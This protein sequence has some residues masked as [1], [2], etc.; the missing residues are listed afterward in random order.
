M[1]VIKEWAV[2]VCAVAIGSSFCVFL[3]PDGKMKK[4][5]ESGVILIILLLICAPLRSNILPDF[6]QAFAAEEVYESDDS[7]VIVLYGRLAEDIISAEIVKIL[8]SV[9]EKS[10]EYEIILESTSENEIILQNII[11]YIDSND[12]FHRDEIESRVGNLTGIVPEV[13]VND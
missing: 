13:T 4:M 3:I 5:A 6:E 7:D 1:D 11:I 9:C 2:M 8:N 12:F 10:F